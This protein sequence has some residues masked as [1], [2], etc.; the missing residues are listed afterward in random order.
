MAWNYPNAGAIETVAAYLA[1][2]NT[3]VR[4]RTAEITRDSVTVEAVGVELAEP[5]VRKLQLKR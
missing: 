3:G 2:G 5:F 1:V 4:K